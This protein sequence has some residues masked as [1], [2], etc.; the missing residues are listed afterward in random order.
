[1]TCSILQQLVW[2]ILRS[3]R[4][5]WQ[6]CTTYVPFRFD[7]DILDRTDCQDN[8]LQIVCLC[9]GSSS[10]TLQFCSL[11]RVQSR[12]QAFRWSYHCSDTRVE[13]TAGANFEYLF[14]FSLLR[15]V[16]TCLSTRHLVGA[17]VARYKTIIHMPVI[18]GTCVGL[19][20]CSSL[21]AN[22]FFFRRAR[23]RT[24]RASCLSS[25][26]RM[27]TGLFAFG[28]VLQVRF[29]LKYRAATR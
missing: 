29:L 7:A 19:H 16:S 25:S 12:S 14:C 2:L 28:C 8:E 3:F 1:M 17:E 15:D 22:A 4:R 26:T 11:S 13:S 27:A 10:K 24:R 23:P 20:L 5:A 21:T 18:C 6:F 9:T